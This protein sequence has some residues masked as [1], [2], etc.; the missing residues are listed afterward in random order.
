MKQFLKENIVNVVMFCIIIGL[1]GYIYYV[2]NKTNEIVCNIENHK[3]GLYTKIENDKEFA[4]L[5]HEN[6]QLYDSLKQF[7][8]EITYLAQFKYEKEYKVDTTWTNKKDTIDK[9]SLKVYQYANNK[10]DSI[11]YDLK[12]GSTKE[13]SWYS[14]NLKVSDKLTIVNK[15]IN[16]TNET[17]I[18]TDNNANVSDVIIYNQSKKR[19]FFQHFNAG[20]GIMAGYD[21]VNKK[22]GIM[23]GFSVTYTIW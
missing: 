11:N 19:T 21:I 8:K 2:S 17:N 20:P 18:K 10:N 7:K 5:K 15:N 1:S 6:K 14:L 12:I 22:P 23:V 3:E 9:D 4:E 16:G 13:P